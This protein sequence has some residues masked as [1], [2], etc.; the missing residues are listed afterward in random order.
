[1]FSTIKS[2]IGK[3]KG[4]VSYKCKYKE[5]DK[6]LFVNELLNYFF[7]KNV[8]NEIYFPI[9]NIKAFKR[10]G[11]E[12]YKVDVYSNNPGVL[13]GKEG[14]RVEQINKFLKNNTKKEVRVQV[15]HS[16]VLNPH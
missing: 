14:W 4:R 16:N 10:R 5:V 8:R 9:T 11:E 7:H 12:F 3:I 15:K 13:I 2:W 6:S 1:M